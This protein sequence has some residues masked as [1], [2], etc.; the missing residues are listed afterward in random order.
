MF[1][2]GSLINEINGNP[3]SVCSAQN[4]SNNIFSISKI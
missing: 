4:N 2:K 3:G 1:T